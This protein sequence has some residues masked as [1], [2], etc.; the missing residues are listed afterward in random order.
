MYIIL[1]L[2]FP[3]GS[4]VKNSPVH[5]GD[6]GSVL[7]SGRSPGK[8]NGNL[9]QYSCLENS[10]DWGAWWDIVHGVAKKSAMTFNLISVVYFDT[11]FL[12]QWF[13]PSWWLPSIPSIWTI[14]VYPIIILCVFFLLLHYKI[15]ILQ[16]LFS[17]S[18]V[19]ITLNKGV[20]HIAS[21]CIIKTLTE[22]SACYCF[23]YTTL[24]SRLCWL[25]D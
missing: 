4:V 23:M 8:V 3:G 7:R 2:S 11:Y 17:F 15:I 6:L 24:S 12:P 18:F 16:A 13:Y 22:Y 1:A 19:H 10:M 21:V 9:L 25:K 5:A 20:Q 14:L